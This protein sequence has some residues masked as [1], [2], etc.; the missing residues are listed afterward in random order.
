MLMGEYDISLYL[1]HVVFV[2][3]SFDIAFLSSLDLNFSACCVHDDNLNKSC[4]IAI[5]FDMH[6][7]YTDCSL[8]TIIER[9]GFTFPLLTLVQLSYFGKV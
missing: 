1:Q 8:L 9:G 7:Y 3:T 4:P 5:N 6:N 2:H